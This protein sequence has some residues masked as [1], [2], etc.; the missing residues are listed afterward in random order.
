MKRRNLFL[1]PLLALGVTVGGLLFGSCRNQTEAPINSL[2]SRG[3]PLGE[4]QKIERMEK[5]HK[6]Y[7]WEIEIPAP[8]TQEKYDRYLLSLDYDSTKKVFD[9]VRARSVLSSL[10][11]SEARSAPPSRIKDYVG[12][13]YPLG[14]V[15]DNQREYTFRLLGNNHSLQN[16]HADVLLRYND[17]D[18]KRSTIEV[19]SSYC[20][21]AFDWQMVRG[22][23]RFYRWDGIGALFRIVITGRMYMLGG[24]ASSSFPGYLVAYIKGFSVSGGYWY[25]AIQDFYPGFPPANWWQ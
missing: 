4:K 24:I 23:A 16:D 8:W 13:L 7:G 2:S 20:G 5:L 11:T 17:R 3:A 10:L 6:E 25:G 18:L 21:G 1:F 22:M 12:V 9:S 19:L 14:P 15:N